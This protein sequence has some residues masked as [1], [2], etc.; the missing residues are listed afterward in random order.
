ILAALL[1]GQIVRSRTQS[2]NKIIPRATK[3][4]EEKSQ[5]SENTEV[6]DV[7]SGNVFL[8]TNNSEAV[9]ELGLFL[10]SNEVEFDQIL[11]TQPPKV[12]LKVD[13]KCFLL[14]MTKSGSLQIQRRGF[15]TKTYESKIQEKKNKNSSSIF[16]Y[17]GLTSDIKTAWRKSTEKESLKAILDS[18]EL[19]GPE[20]AKIAFAEGYF[21]G[22]L[23]KT[24]KFG[25]SSFLLLSLVV[26]IVYFYFVY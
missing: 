9:T 2:R 3:I 25:F 15:R 26:G 18:T 1:N 24:S 6:R 13:D 16:S 17:F 4:S 21:A 10:R 12:H 5:R 22:A 8:S 19:K 23:R 11:F 14:S 20:K 7:N